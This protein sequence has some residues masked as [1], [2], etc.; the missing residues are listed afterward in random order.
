[1]TREYFTD[2][3]QINETEENEFLVD[4]VQINET[5]VAAAGG[6]EGAAM[7]HHLQNMGVY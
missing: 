6:N 3:V 2:E 4:G 7:Y 5:V 1:M